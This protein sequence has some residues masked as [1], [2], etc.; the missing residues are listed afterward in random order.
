M[1]EEIKDYSVPVDAFCVIRTNWKFHI[2][3]GVENSKP[4]WPVRVKSWINRQ[5]PLPRTAAA[6]CSSA[7]LFDSAV[8]HFDVGVQFSSDSGMCSFITNRIIREV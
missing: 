7:V 6:N 3:F 4:D 1:T 8:C 5:R 2:Q